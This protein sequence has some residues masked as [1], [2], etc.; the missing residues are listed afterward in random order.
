MVAEIA[1]NDFDRSFL[2][3][4]QSR[5]LLP[6]IRKSGLLPPLDAGPGKR[7]PHARKNRLIDLDDRFVFPVSLRI[8]LTRLGQVAIFTEIDAKNTQD[9]G[10]Q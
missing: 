6:G 5:V 8:V 10:G 7:K 1:F 2:Q 3:I 4:I 9:L